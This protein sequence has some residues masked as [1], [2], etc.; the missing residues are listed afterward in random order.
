MDEALLIIE[1]AMFLLF[2]ALLFRKER[3]YGIYFFFIYIYAI[4]VQI[5]YLYVPVPSFHS[6]AYFGEEIWQNVTLFILLSGITL[7]LFLYYCSPRILK[8]MRST[9]LCMYVYDGKRVSSRRLV[10]AF[11]VINLIVQ[12]CIFFIS[13]NELTWSIAQGDDL[14]QVH[15][16][17]GTFVYLLKFS[18]AT[19]I[20]LY[21]TLRQSISYKNNTGLFLLGLFSF[22]SFIVFTLKIGNRSDLIAVIL[23]IVVFETSQ[24]IITF[25]KLAGI[26][27]F[28]VALIAYSYF[29]GNARAES[30]EQ[31]IDLSLQLLRQDYF[32]PAHILFAAVAFNYVK[33]SE[34]ILSNTANTLFKLNYPYLQSPITDLFA[35]GVATRS[36]GF[37]FYTFTEGYV[38]AGFIGFLYNGIVLGAL[39]TFWR[40]LAMTNSK[41]F[42]YFLLAIMGSMVIN[43]VRGQSSY[44]IKYLY[45]FILPGTL[46]YLALT[47][48]HLSLRIRRRR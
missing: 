12:Y 2:S 16:L 19:N 45:T 5:G 14:F 36:Q 35:S 40:S 20:A 21:C 46:I 13:Y 29:L 1:S 10:I 7:F 8:K 18:D 11:I 24:I 39:M 38:F 41:K 22:I 43:V 44:Y 28:G 30:G 31:N 27:F 25:R 34:V 9:R 3:I 32:G 26:C 15:F 23:G 48:Q 37:G 4:F 47:K 42:N 17:V 33:P 6:Q